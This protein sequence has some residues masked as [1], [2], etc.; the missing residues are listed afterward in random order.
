VGL[1]LI[2]GRLL[3]GYFMDR[4]IGPYVA[5]IFVLVPLAGVVMLAASVARPILMVSAVVLGL[6]IGAEVDML[7]FLAGRYFGLRAY[8]AIYGALLGLFMFGSGFGPW[9]MSV[10]FARTNAYT[11]ALGGF[12]VML[13]G[14]AVLIARLGPY[15]Y[16][17][18]T[19]H[20][21]DA[22]DG[23]ADRRSA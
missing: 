9:L 6:G 7:A 1:A 3:S 5:A 14:S 12:A 20:T 23:R 19:V 16:A 15:R 4:F 21:A 17:V 11:V 10:S 13:F 2:A 22:P 8:G 18:G